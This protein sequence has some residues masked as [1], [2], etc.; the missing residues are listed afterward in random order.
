[1]HRGPG[2][3]LHRLLR[4]ELDLIVISPL[5]AALL[6]QL[7]MT[8]AAITVNT[9]DVSY[10]SSAG[11]TAA[12]V[13]TLT[14]LDQDLASSRLRR[15]PPAHLPPQRALAT[16]RTALVQLSP[17]DAGRPCQAGGSG[18]LVRLEDRLGHATRRK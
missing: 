4:G 6:N 13:L 16:G 17:R 2:G 12:R 3:E 11:G 15:P 8:Q 7:S 10:L 1:M 14:G 9:G 5:R 18:G